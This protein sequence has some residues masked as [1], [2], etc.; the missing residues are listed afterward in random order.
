MEA[1]S[2]FC[3]SLSN[4][5][6]SVVQW[7]S[8]VA[9]PYFM[10]INA[11]FWWSAFYIDRSIQIRSL[12]SLATIIFGW[13]IL[14]SSSQERSILFHIISW[15]IR[16]I[17]RTVS[18]GAAL[19]SAQAIR[20]KELEK[21]CWAAYISVALV[22]LNPVWQYYQAPQRISSCFD[23]VVTT[24]GHI[25]HRFILLP[26]RLL[27]QGT[28]Y[29]ILLRWVP[30]LW[31]LL[32]RVVQSSRD[33]IVHLVSMVYLEL[34]ARAT[35][36]YFAVVQCFHSL[37]LRT[38]KAVRYVE[39][40]I[41]AAFIAARSHLL[42]SLVACKTA[43]VR[44]ISGVADS[45]ASFFAMI[46]HCL[47]R[48]VLGVKSAI[49]DVLAR[50]KHYIVQKWILAVNTVCGAVR[51]SKDLVTA[52]VQ[53]ACSAVLQLYLNCTTWVRE[54][55][56][57]P[58]QNAS[59]AAF[60][61]L[62]YWICAYWWPDLRSWLIARIKRRLQ[63][64]FNYVCFGLVYIFHGY[65]IEPASIYLIARLKLLYAYTQRT[66]LS[67]FSR[68]LRR[69]VDVAIKRLE[70]VLRQSMV[71]VRDSLIW[72][73]CLLLAALLEQLFAYLYGILVQPVVDALYE[74]YKLCEDCMLIYLLA[75]TCKIII[76]HIPERSPFCDDTDTELA[77]LL[78][79]GFEDSNSESETTPEKSL[80]SSRSMSLTEDEH[81]LS[82]GLRFPNVDVSD[83]S[84]DD[85][86]LVPRTKLRKHS[87][88]ARKKIPKDPAPSTAVVRNEDNTRH[89]HS[90]G[91]SQSENS[92]LQFGPDESPIEGLSDLHALDVFDSDTESRKVVALLEDAVEQAT[93]KQEKTA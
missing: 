80:I 58:V 57:K 52:S 16:S 8:P 71:A 87:R 46:G 17:L 26:S 45:I 25:T 85:F 65:W 56:V 74:K 15:P 75:P 55:I 10:L 92:S 54:K 88:S 11:A 60:H 41:V 3:H 49:G 48:T 22:V 32:K 86:S 84:E 42:K 19:Y 66:V 29:V 37:M 1:L 90:T 50:I 44:C 78:P 93:L 82:Y 38:W 67:P 33:A 5:A 77:D 12:Y 79:S 31:D 36:V 9:A 61:F 39:S 20:Q 30:A 81:E 6:L 91:S 7:R 69:C 83:S 64:T 35:A 70:Q 2:N 14:L 18:V 53:V 27:Y 28:K 34:H 43:V 59:R 73:F 40:V 89:P 4:Y 23:A 72:P 62:R 68:W 63:R 51:S 47:L 24:V 76:D 21:A 13:D